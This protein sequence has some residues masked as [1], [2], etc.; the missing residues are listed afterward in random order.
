MLADIKIPPSVPMVGR[1]VTAPNPFSCGMEAAPNPFVLRYRST[2]EDGT[3]TT[4]EGW[5]ESCARPSIHQGE[6]L[7]AASLLHENGWVLLPYYMR[8]VGCCLPIG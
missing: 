2:N 6:R 5:A 7:G 1:G 4:K 3:D 8:T